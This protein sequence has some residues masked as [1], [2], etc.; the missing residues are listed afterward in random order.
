VNGSTFDVE[1]LGPNETR[2]LLVYE[3]R[4][5]IGKALNLTYSASS[6]RAVTDSRFT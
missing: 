1:G 6:P 2:D 4:G 3:H 5:Q